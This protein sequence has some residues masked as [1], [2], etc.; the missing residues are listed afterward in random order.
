MSE[1]VCPNC[2]VDD[3][4]SGERDGELIRI[5]CSD[6]DLVWD[7]ISA[8]MPSICHFRIRVFRLYHPSARRRM[9]MSVVPQ[10]G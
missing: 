7:R 1:I 8:L 2:G 6:C 3:H 4:L 9:L 5:T 10:R